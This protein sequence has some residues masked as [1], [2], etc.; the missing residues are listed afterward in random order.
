MIKC[1]IEYDLD[2]LFIATN[3]PGGS[4]FNRC[5]RRMAPL[6]RELSGVILDH[7]HF[8]SHLN[9]K[10]ETIDND[11]EVKKF[12]Y[13]GTVLAEIWSKLTIDGHPV[14]AEYVSDGADE[15]IPGKS[16]ECISMHVKSSQYLLNTSRIPVVSLS[17]LPTTK[18]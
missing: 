17:V 18:L 5:E 6:S 4:A 13:A 3:A 14:V 12:E 1:A 10:G 16:Q 7:D 2:C 15:D 8:G 9:E 11:L